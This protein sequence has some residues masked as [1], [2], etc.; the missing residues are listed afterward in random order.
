ME[1]IKKILN[2]LSKHLYIIIGNY[3]KN[4]GRFFLEKKL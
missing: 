1:D 3:W 2:L 4:I